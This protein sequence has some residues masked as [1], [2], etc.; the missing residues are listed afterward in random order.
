MS[1]FSLKLIAG[2]MTSLFVSSF[3]ISYFVLNMYGVSV[4]GIALP[5]SLQSYS[6]SQNFTSG[7]YN[8]TTLSKTGNAG[9]SYVPNVGM[10]LTSFGAYKNYFLID[11]V[12]KDSS[13]TVTNTYVINNSVGGDYTIVLR[14]TGGYDNNEFI[15]KNDGLYIPYYLAYFGIVTSEYKFA[16]I[17][18]ANKIVHP[19]IKTI[20][21]DGKQTCNW[22]GTCIHTQEPYLSVNFNGQ[23]FETTK[24]MYPD[25][26]A[27]IYGVY[28]GG[29]KSDTLGFV[30]DSYVT[31]NLIQGGGT[32][33]TNTF[34][35]VSSFINSMITMLT[36]RMSTDILPY[37]F[38]VL[39]FGTQEFLL[40][41]GI[42]GFIR[43]V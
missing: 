24:L 20:Y 15:V 9:W 26:P 30:F 41:V 14:Y 18:N 38:Q 12:V 22:L 8:L 4:A 32:E 19:T 27:N 37:N 31:T 3:L 6:S 17:P 21:R 34:A 29:V 10:M 23:N 43:G 25:N 7:Q 11:N 1:S 13:N 33:N 40:L 5:D 39:F 36:W 42:A 2:T 28:Y 16:S 35:M